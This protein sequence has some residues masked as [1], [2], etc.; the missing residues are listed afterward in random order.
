MNLGIEVE[1]DSAFEE[2]FSLRKWLLDEPAF[3]GRIDLR[4]RPTEPGTMGLVP[5]TLTLALGGGTLAGSAVGV[6]NLLKVVTLWLNSR[7]GSVD[8]RIKTPDGAA[9]TVKATNVH[10][11]R[12][13]D[14]QRAI[15]DLARSLTSRYERDDAQA[16]DNGGS[17]PAA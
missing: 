13:A 2:L 12:G 3:R 1:G 17:S 7:T 8:V 5:E 9:V 16:E 6:R 14:L 4:T 10:G 15:E 11:L